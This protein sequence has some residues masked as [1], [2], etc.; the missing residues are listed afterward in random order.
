MDAGRQ[1]NAHCSIWVERTV[2]WKRGIYCS[3]KAS[4]FSPS[5]YPVHFNLLS[6]SATK[7]KMFGFRLVCIMINCDM[8]RR[9]SQGKWPRENGKFC[10]LIFSLFFLSIFFLQQEWCLILTTMRKKNV[11]LP[12]NIAAVFCF[13]FSLQVSD[14]SIKCVKPHES[15]RMIAC[16]SA[17]GSVHLMEVS[18][19]MTCSAKNDKAILNAVSWM[20]KKS[21]L[22]ETM[23]LP[24]IFHFDFL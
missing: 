14:H 15:G 11:F 22:L 20:W 3:S 9:T 2:I 1:Q 6:L 5:R 18:E 7:G 16:G 21:F 24:F 19:N 13:S 23:K 10:K 8:K 4:Q 17:N 12:C